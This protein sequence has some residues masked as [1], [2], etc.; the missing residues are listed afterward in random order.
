MQEV[1]FFSKNKIF[2]GNLPEAR[3]GSSIIRNTSFKGLANSLVLHR[4]ES[5]QIIWKKIFQLWK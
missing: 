3:A 5:S 4:V 2:H 1:F